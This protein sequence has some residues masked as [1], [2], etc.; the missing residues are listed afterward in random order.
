MSTDGN[1]LTPQ[2]AGYYEGVTDVYYAL[3][4][5]AGSGV[6][7]P[8]YGAVKALG[9]SI[10]LQVTPNYRE[11][12]VYASNAATRREQLPES[13]SVSLNLDQVI[14]EVRTEVLGRKD[15]G[16]GVELI[17]GKNVGPWLAIMFAAT[18]D[19]GSQEYRTLYRGRFS[20]P[21]GTHHTKNDGDSYQHPTIQATFVPVAY[22]ELLSTEFSTDGLGYARNLLLGTRAG[23]TDT[24][25]SAMAVNPS[26]GPRYTLSDEAVERLKSGETLK[27]VHGAKLHYTGTG[28]GD[29]EDGTIPVRLG[30]TDGTALTLVNPAYVRAD[31]EYTSQTADVKLTGVYLNKTPAYITW[32]AAGWENTNWLVTISAARLFAGGVMY[33][34]SPAP[35]DFITSVVVPD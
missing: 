8:T 17:T 27:L 31:T 23:G 24:P 9:K 2:N 29:V 3:M 16:D 11:R 21:A 22:H 15:G 5:N 10:E 35:E 19:D 20:E 1:T 33:P 4:L 34:W 18:L 6:T 26:R 25:L 32:G 13:Y 30:F 28:T 7:K 14:P 12:K